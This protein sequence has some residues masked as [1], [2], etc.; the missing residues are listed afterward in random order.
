MDRAMGKN[1]MWLSGEPVTKP[2]MI[3]AGFLHLCT[4]DEPHQT[5]E[6]EHTYDVGLAA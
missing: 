5:L 1:C 3:V 2:A 4:T 6:A